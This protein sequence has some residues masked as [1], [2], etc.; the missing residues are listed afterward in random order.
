M[1]CKTQWC[2]LIL[3]T[4]SPWFSTK[5]MHTVSGSTYTMCPLCMFAIIGRFEQISYVL[6]ARLSFLAHTLGCLATNK[7]HAVPACE[8]AR[9]PRGTSISRAMAR[10]I[11]QDMR[12]HMRDPNHARAG[13]GTGNAREPVREQPTHGIP[14][15]SLTRS[16]NGGRRDG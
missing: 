10:T 3:I 13:N 4:H 8:K 5:N 14:I 11:P 12:G 1:S 16:P 2:T 9:E 7:M 6:L 15:L